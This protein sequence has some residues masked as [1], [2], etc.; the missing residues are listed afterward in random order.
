M[1]YRLGNQEI[2]LSNLKKINFTPSTKAGDVYRYKNMAIR[3]FRDGEEPIDKQTADYF[4]RISTARILLPRQLLIYNSSL[5]KGYSM[6]LVTQ[7]GSG[8]RITI[9]PKRELIEGVAAL[10]RDNETLSQKKVLLNGINPGY[11]LYNGE[12]YL[13]NPA[14]YSRLELGNTKSLEK[15]NQFQI[16]LLITELIASDL[17][18]SRVPQATI[19]EV[20]KL[21][22]LKDMDERTS[23]FL[24]ELLRGQENVKELVKKMS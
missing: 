4:T 1:G 18:K 8:K 20:K 23:S 22:S 15:L 11:V 13:V 12:I 19:N 21:L 14:G 2:E 10:E 5:F 7:K 6:K 17:R 3:V 9:A 24:I 16:H